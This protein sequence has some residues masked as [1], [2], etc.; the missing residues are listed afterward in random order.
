MYEDGKRRDVVIKASLVV[1]YIAMDVVQKRVVRKCEPAEL[2]MELDMPGEP[3]SHTMNSET[4]VRSYH[5][6]KKEEVLAVQDG[7]SGSFLLPVK[8]KRYKYGYV[9]NKKHSVKVGNK[10]E[11]KLGTSGA[12]EM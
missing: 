12:L 3:L 11:D 7:S 4:E 2:A 6:N 10:T 9:E 8:K 1:K 5:G